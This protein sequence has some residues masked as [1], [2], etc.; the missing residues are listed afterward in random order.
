MARQI[1]E[2]VCW[3]EGDEFADAYR[4]GGERP[5]NRFRTAVRVLAE[6]ADAL[7]GR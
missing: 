5:C 1:M 3:V 7:D 4:R 6:A 2:V